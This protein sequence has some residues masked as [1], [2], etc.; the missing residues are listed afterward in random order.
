MINGDTV[1]SAIPGLVGVGSII[2]Q[3]E[4]AFLGKLVNSTRPRP[5]HQFLP[6]GSCAVCIPVLTSFNDGI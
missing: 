6:L 2:K 1:G 4:Q 3:T 5:L